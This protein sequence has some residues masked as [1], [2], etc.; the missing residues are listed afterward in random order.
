MRIFRLDTSGEKPLQIKEGMMARV[1]SRKLLSDL[2][3]H[4]LFRLRGVGAPIASKGF[5][6]RVSKAHW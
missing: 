1:L 4:N 3:L 5:F 2:I 6:G